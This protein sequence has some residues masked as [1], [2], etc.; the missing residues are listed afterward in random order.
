MV[1]RFLAIFTCIARS[2]CS[3][4]HSADA[5]WERE[6]ERLTPGWQLGKLS[7]SERRFLFE[8]LSTGK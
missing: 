5:T 3:R 8:A 7:L 4:R 1:S 2:E 6:L